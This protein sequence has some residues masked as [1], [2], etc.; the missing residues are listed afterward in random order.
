MALV[1]NM[2]I[3]ILVFTIIILR[4]AKARKQVITSTAGVISVLSVSKCANF[5]KNT[6]FNNPRNNVIDSRQIK[7]VFHP[8]LRIKEKMNE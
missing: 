3:T 6:R 4:Q 1:Y 5:I 2:N 8:F 7:L